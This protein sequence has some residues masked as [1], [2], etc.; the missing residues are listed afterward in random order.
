MKH[1]LFA[2]VLA[3]PE[4]PERLAAIAA[5]QARYRGAEALADHY[6]ADR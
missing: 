4:T 5:A 3:A 1:L 6:D 2:A